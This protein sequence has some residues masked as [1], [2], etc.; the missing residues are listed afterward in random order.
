MASS[1]DQG[2]W[3]HLHTVFDQVVNNYIL[4]RTS[5][6]PVCAHCVDPDGSGSSSKLSPNDIHYVADVELSM[7]RVLDTEE[8]QGAFWT[9]V[10]ANAELPDVQPVSDEIA[11]QVKILCGGI[12]AKR[13]LH[14]LFEYYQPSKQ[15]G[16]KRPAA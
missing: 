16:S 1:F 6:S 12:F 5:R 11:N 8:M 15:R 7:R 10:A 14:K 3:I 2:S 4:I 9:L 13:R